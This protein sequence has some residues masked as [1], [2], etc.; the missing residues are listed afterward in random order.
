MKKRLLWADFVRI[1]AIY[2]VLVIHSFNTPVRISQNHFDTTL[3]TSAIATTCVPLFVMLSGALLLGKQE[4]YKVFFQKRFIRLMGPWILWTSFY[5]ILTTL[6]LHLSSFQQIL[7]EFTARWESF[8]FLPM[9]AGLY[10]LTPAIRIF[11][12][13]ARRQDIL[14]ILILWFLSV[15]FFPYLHNSLAFPM[16]VDDG[17]VRQIVN[18]YGYYLFGYFLSEVKLTNSIFSIVLVLAGTFW[19][20]AAV[21]A[22]SLQNH[23]I[24]V[25]DFNNY[26][27]PSIVVL[28]TGMFLLL[29]SLGEYMQKNLLSGFTKGYMVIAYISTSALGIYFIHPLVQEFIFPQI[30]HLSVNPPF[31]PLIKGAILFVTSFAILSLLSLIPRARQLLT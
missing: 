16:H 27:S 31:D 3:I 24:L 7:R 22:M 21:Y 2:L 17:L 5:T 26:V 14:L 6:T 29:F 10:I 28:S 1:G 15:S 20:C 13:A 8:W 12:R 4:S 30:S 9:I 19:T 18:F 11:I 23:G 25:S